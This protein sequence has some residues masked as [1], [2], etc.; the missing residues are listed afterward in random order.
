MFPNATINPYYLI[1]FCEHGAYTRRLASVGLTQAR[2]NT[3][4][5]AIDFKFFSIAYLNVYNHTTLKAPV[6]I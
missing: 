1:D 3:I 5:S 6:L 4:V 2:P